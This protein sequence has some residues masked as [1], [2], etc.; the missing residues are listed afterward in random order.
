MS[1]DDNFLHNPSMQRFKKLMPGPTSGAAFW[2]MMISIGISIP[3][4]LSFIAYFIF[5]TYEFWMWVFAGVAGIAAL[6]G[7]YLFLSGLAIAAYLTVT[8]QWHVFIGWWLD[9]LARIGDQFTSVR[10]SMRI[11]RQEL[12]EPDALKPEERNGFLLSMAAPQRFPKRPTERITFAD[13]RHIGMVA[14]NRSGKGRAFIIPNLAHWL[15]SAIIYD[16]S[17]ENYM[18]TARYRR[19]VLGQKVV[20][21]DPFGVTGDPTDS[22]NPLHE[23]DFENDPLAIDKCHVV[24]ESLVPLEGDKPYWTHAARKMI[25][26]LI[27][28]VG[29]NALREHVHLTQVRDLLLSGDPSSLWIAMARNEAFGGLIR[30]FAESNEHRAESEL[31][32]TMETARTA[33]KWLDSGVVGQNTSQSSFSMRELKTGKVSVYIVIPAGMGDTYKAWMRLL[34]DAAFEA[35]QDL[36]IP[37]PEHSTLFFLDEFP[38]LGKMDRIKRAAG[39]SAK[40]GV[41]LFVCAQD[42]GQLKEIYGEAWETFIA[43]AGVLIMFSNND[44]LSQKYLSARLGKEYFKSYTHSS[45]RGGNSSSYTMQ[46]REVARPDQVEKQVSRQSGDAYVFISGSKPLRLPRANYDQWGL[47]SSSAV[48]SQQA[49]KPLSLPHVD[50]EASSVAAE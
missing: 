50:A 18:A 47:L 8:K 2:L 30:R 5:Q 29:T 16:P 45:G 31:G 43:N 38:L 37:K 28:F 27:A 14:N 17:G 15:G 11:I 35:M 46:L 7:L 21:L 4:V 39:E 32:S 41:K 42:I 24:S 40:F 26:M 44:L 1:F 13:D 22:W 9:R 36:S 33:M 19:E 20:L 48:E 34:F 6:V 10:S 25:S 23:I 49:S 12:G 3:I